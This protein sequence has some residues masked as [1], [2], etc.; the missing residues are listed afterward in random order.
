MSYLSN[1]KVEGK[2]GR[3]EKHKED[4]CKGVMLFSTDSLI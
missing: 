3:D 1:V 2:Q 4:S